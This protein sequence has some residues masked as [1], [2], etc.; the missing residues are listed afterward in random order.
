MSHY[1][2]LRLIPPNQHRRHAHENGM[3]SQPDAIPRPWRR[4]LRFRVRGLIVLGL[5]IGAGLGWVVREAHI[6]RDAVAAIRKVGGKVF[7]GWEWRNYTYTSGGKPWA[8][9]WFV[10]LIGV[11]YFGHVTAVGLISSSTAD[12]TLAHV[13][14]LTGLRS[15]S[16]YKSN[17]T[18]AGL[19]H[20][21][22]MTNLSDLGLKDTQITDAGIEDLTQAAPSLTIYR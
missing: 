16:L 6:Q 1:L 7:S 8:P 22:R 9:R 20:L 21:K 4:F 13:G 2:F 19:V 3:S 18:D 11:D 10:D 15:L 17:V 12:A 5:V 14:R